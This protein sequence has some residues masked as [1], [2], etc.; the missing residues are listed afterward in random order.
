MADSR[1]S[2]FVDAEAIAA[3]LSHPERISL[4]AQPIVDLQRAT[5]VGYELLARFALGHTIPPPAVFAGAVRCGHGPELEALVLARALA[6][7]ERKPENCFVAINVDPMNLTAPEVK[8]AIG[9]TDLRGVVFEMTEHSAFED[10]RAV[11]LAIDVLR[12][13]GAIIALDDAGAG[14]PGL[15]QIIELRPEIIKLD[16]DLVSGLHSNEAKRVLVE[17]LGGLAD[18][19]DAWVLAE[20]VETPEEADAVV[21]LGIPLAQGYFFCVP[22]PGW[23]AVSP[24]ALQLVLSA[25]VSRRVERLRDRVDRV[26]SPCQTTPADVP[27][28]ARASVAVRVDATRRPMAMQLVGESG[29]LVRGAGELMRIK[30]DELLVDVVRR[31]IARPERLRWDPMLCVDDRG[32]LEGVVAFERLV[33]ALAENTRVEDRASGVEKRAAGTLASSPWRHR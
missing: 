32:N 10:I 14:Y 8:A 6:L 4:A 7:F 25:M 9:K 30:R 22:R 3:I 19:L 28:P 21:K 33:E 26:V 2:P 15:K 31:A 24:D 17:M 20:G 13:Q 27:W 12:D 16:R 18:Q 1:G 11:R 5:V 29:P 23:S